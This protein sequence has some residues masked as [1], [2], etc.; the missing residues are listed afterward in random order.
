M[1]GEE[2]VYLLWRRKQH[3]NYLVQTLGRPSPGML[4]RS[5]TTGAT[6]ETQT[7]R[8]EVG[9]RAAFF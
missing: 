8:A 3:G 4:F 9:T 6:P 7:G 2:C 1:Y 5:Q